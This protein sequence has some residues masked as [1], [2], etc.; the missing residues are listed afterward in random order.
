MTLHK[1]ILDDLMKD[2]PCNKED[3]EDERWCFLKELITHC[4]LQDREAEQL[5]LIYDYKFMQSKKEEQDIGSARA[6][7]EFIAQYA[8]TFNEVYQPGMKHEYLFEKVFGV[9][10]MPTDAQIRKMF[11]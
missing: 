1:E 8:K 5:R 2:C 7:T 9:K 6:F 10:L 3:C 4:G 11:D